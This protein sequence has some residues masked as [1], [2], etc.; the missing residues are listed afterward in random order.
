MEGFEP[1]PVVAQVLEPQSA[2]RA[3]A[4]VQAALAQVPVV[5]QLQAQEPERLASRLELVVEPDSDSVPELEPQRA[6]AVQ[7]SPVDQH[8]E[9][10]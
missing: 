6:S 8:L 10:V 2:V 9:S 5:A 4:R 7:G 3:R 1:A